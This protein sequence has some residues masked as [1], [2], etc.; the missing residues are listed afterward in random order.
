MFTERVFLFDVDGTLTPHRGPMH[1]DF[2]R[3]F[4]EFV[5]E[6][7]FYLTTGSDLPK[8]REQV[9]A[10]ILRAASGIFCCAGNQLYVDGGNT[11]VYENN[12]IPSTDLTDCLRECVHTSEYEVKTGN[13]IELRPGMINFSVV[14]RNANQSQRYEYSDYDNRVGERNKIIELLKKK[15][16]DL[17]FTIGGQISIDIFPMGNDKS[18]SAR[19]VKQ[20]EKTGYLVYVGDRA[21]PGGN[22]YAACKEIESR[23]WG[24]WF[25]VNNYKETRAILKQ[26]ALI[27]NKDAL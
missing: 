10:T 5:Q 23:G 22:D 18:M 6:N 7:K 3:F 19:W 2:Y 25:N 14:G 26:F 21:F 4:S 17:D 8:T 20:N 1:G 13:H 11:L 24:V 9:P 27:K 16:H 12:F 15:Y